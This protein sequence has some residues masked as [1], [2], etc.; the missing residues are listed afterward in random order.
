MKTKLNGIGKYITIQQL[1]LALKK[2]YVKYFSFQ[3]QPTNDECQQL[4]TGLF[5][6]SNR[7]FVKRN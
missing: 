1:D 7:Q 2:N 4:V 5:N 3:Y 6:P